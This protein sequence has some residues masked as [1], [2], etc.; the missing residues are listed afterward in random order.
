MVLLKKNIT[1]VEL[2]QS[3]VYDNGVH[4]KIWVKVA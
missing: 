2:I 3:M 1:I 4:Q